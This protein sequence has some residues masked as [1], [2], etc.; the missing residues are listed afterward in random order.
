MTE[1]R[2]QV[3]ARLRGT[4]S[5]GGL[6][7][8]RRAMTRGRDQVSNPVGRHKVSNPWA[9]VSTLSQSVQ[10][11]LDLARDARSDSRDRLQL[12]VTD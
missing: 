6:A 12:S 4:R 5:C 1:Q 10:N 8:A 7:A 9:R 3:G 2:L 11:G